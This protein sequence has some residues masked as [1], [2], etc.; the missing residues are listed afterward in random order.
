MIYQIAFQFKD[1]SDERALEL[2]EKLVLALKDDVEENIRHT[3]L[4]KVEN[5]GGVTH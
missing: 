5:E 1:V 2:A 4:I 3:D